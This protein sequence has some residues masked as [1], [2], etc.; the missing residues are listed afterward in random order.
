[1]GHK[2]EE[3]YKAIYRRDFL[4]RTDKNLWH[5]QRAREIRKKYD[6]SQLEGYDRRTFIDILLLSIFNAIV[7]L[8]LSHIFKDNLLML[9][10]SAWIIGGYFTCAA[11]LGMHECSHNL[12]FST[13]T[14]NFFT[15]MISDLPLFLPAFL[16]FRHYH[17][18]HHSYTTIDLGEKN[19][20]SNKDNKK[21]P[22]Y[23]PDLPTEFEA[24]L[25]S[26]SCITRLLFLVFQA[27]AYA[28][29]PMIQSPKKFDFFDYVSIAK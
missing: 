20:P 18:P 28:I 25:F 6:V 26:Y 29:R 8:I 1:M 13:W 22:K 2:E 7:T 12:V 11:A 15:G 3:E 21:L 24:F 4:W 19:K 14:G 16:S 27:F 23:D 10:L 9:F 17:L 5:A